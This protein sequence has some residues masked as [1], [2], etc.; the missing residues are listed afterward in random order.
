[1]GS[2]QDLLKA[3]D[4]AAKENNISMSNVASRYLLEQPAVA[5]V[6]IGTRLGKE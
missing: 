2:I 5:G 4:T 3:I 1:M 6:I